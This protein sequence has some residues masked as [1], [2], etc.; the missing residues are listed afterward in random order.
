MNTAQELRYRIINILEIL[1]V[2]NGA[3][4]GFTFI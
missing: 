4:I 2:M 1:N 3:V